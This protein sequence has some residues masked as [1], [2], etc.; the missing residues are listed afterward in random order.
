MPIEGSPLRRLVELKI[1]SIKRKLWEDFDA[2]RTVAIASTG[3][4][5]EDILRDVLAQVAILD[6]TFSSTEA[7]RAAAKCAVHV[8]SE[9]AKNG[10]A[11]FRFLSFSLIF[12]CVLENYC[13]IY[14]FSI[15]RC[16]S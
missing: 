7:D 16:G 10:N 15:K 6:S 13:C 2:D 9:L 3:R 5:Q 12:V 8:L 4:A 14:V 11:G 1:N